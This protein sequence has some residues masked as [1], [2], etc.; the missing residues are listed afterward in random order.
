MSR[1]LDSPTMELLGDRDI[2]A[3]PA[4]TRIF[5]IMTGLFLS[6]TEI[7]KLDLKGEF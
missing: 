1:R 5:D 3:P 6:K 7:I 2:G 4:A